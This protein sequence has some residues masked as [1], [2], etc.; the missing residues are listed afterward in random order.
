[1]LTTEQLKAMVAMVV[2]VSSQQGDELGAGSRIHDVTLQH[3]YKDF[4]K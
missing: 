1:M 3:V 4:K 2:M